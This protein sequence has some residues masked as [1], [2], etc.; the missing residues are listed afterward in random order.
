VAEK[1]KGRLADLRAANCVNDLI[2]GR[3]RELQGDRVGQVALS[4]GDGFQLVFCANHRVVP[5]VEGS[6][7]DWSRVNR[8][9]I[10]SIEGNRA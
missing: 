6:H 4:L 7:V 1:L 3:P 10:M 5:L 9:K 2:A 8:V